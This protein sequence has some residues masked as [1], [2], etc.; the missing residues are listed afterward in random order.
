MRGGG[1]DAEFIAMLALDDGAGVRLRDAD[2]TK[3]NGN[4]DF[5]SVFHTL[6]KLKNC[7]KVEISFQSHFRGIIC[8]ALPKI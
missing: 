3:K 1:F 8:A 6:A 5:S 2:G 7:A 4:V